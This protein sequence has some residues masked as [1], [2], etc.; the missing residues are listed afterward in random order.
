MFGGDAGFTFNKTTDTATLGALSLTN[1][2]EQ[3]TALSEARDQSAATTTELFWVA[4][5]DDEA[6]DLVT[7]LYR[8][9]EMVSEHDRLGVKSIGL[10]TTFLRL[11][12]PLFRTGTLDVRCN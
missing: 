10:V 4:T 9:R 1:P 3:K 12:A 5:L 6:R 11:L 7:E 8:S 2:L